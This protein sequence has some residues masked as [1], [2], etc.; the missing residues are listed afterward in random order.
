MRIKLLLSFF[1]VAFI[2]I[3]S[4]VAIMLTT[5][6]RE[7]HAFMLRGGMI[8]ANE[9]VRVLEDYYEENGSWAGV[10]RL[11]SSPGRGMMHGGQGQGRQGFGGMM[12][13][14]GQRLRLA[15]AQGNILVDTMDAQDGEVLSDAEIQDAIRLVNGRQTV[16]YLLPEGGMSIGLNAQRNLLGRINRAAFTSALI[17]GAI[18]LFLALLL[19]SRL[20]RPVRDLIGASR[21]LAAGNLSHRV[22]VKGDDEIAELGWSFN[23]MA[24]S[25]QAAG[26]SRRAMTADIAHELRTPLAVQRAQLEA[27]QDG[28]Y[29]LTAENLSPVLEQNIM[30]TRLVE[31][32]RTLA[33]AD[34]GRLQMDRKPVDL[35]E[36]VR[37][38]VEHFAPRAAAQG[39]EI[40]FEQRDELPQIALDSTR[41]EQ[42]LGNLLANALR[43]TPGGGE[44]RINLE[45]EGKSAR[46]A[47]HD[48]GPG[49]PEDVMPHIF[50][51]FYRADRSRSREQGGTGLGLAIARQLAEAHGG[52]L[53]AGN[54]PGGGAIFVLIL[55]FD[56]R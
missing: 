28:I 27:L 4:M 38:V 14:M 50:E 25:L 48:S 15:D 30:L 46:L 19:A 44:I 34:A 53:S 3:A 13:M 18:S 43:H 6:A 9:L 47:V 7:V 45:K 21:S 5:T 39:V 52:S 40:R 42:I 20:L 23:K 37:K 12:A 36:I 8:G 17:A 35:A 10:E 29:P 55:P 26:E 16:G 56:A 22:V 54:H 1:L 41:V 31:D 51:R 2:T 24:E 11:L 33:L 32:L 49:I